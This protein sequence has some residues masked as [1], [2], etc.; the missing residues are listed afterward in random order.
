MKHAATT[1]SKE[2]SWRSAIVGGSAEV[3]GE[4]SLKMPPIIFSK[5]SVLIQTGRMTRT[6]PISVVLV[7]S[8]MLRIARRLAPVAP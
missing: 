2:T 6:P 7:N 4:S 1:I 3:T 5:R 8:A